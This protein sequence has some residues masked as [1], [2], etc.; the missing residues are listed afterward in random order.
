M[1]E[2]ANLELGGVGEEITI[3]VI[4]ADLATLSTFTDAESGVSLTI[5]NNE[6]V[7]RTP[8]KDASVGT[9]LT[10]KATLEGAPE[11]TGQTATVAVAKLEIEVA[12]KTVDLSGTD[13]NV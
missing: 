1:N 3:P 10:L 5:E 11:G 4:L 9:T 13:P 2:N 12:E 8:V 7:L 6:S